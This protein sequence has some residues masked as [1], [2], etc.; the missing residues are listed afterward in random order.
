MVILLILRQSGAFFHFYPFL[1]RLLSLT[2]VDA[3][4][5]AF[6]VTATS[7]VIS[8]IV[9]ERLAERYLPR[10]SA[11]IATTLYFLV[12]YVFLY[13]AVS[14]TEPVFIQIATN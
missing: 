13:S 10:S 1:I 12:P 8:L 3:V 5:L 7:G 4:F 11:V 2:G 14:Y 6:I 9:F